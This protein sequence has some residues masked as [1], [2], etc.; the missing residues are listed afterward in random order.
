MAL[1]KIAIP[2]ILNRRATRVVTLITIGC[3]VFQVLFNGVG[4]FNIDSTLFLAILL[5]AFGV[6]LRWRIFYWLLI[7]ALGALV[8]RS[9]YAAYSLWNFYLTKEPPA[10]SERFFNLIPF[11]SVNVLLPCLLLSYYVFSYIVKNEE[12]EK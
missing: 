5:F 8:I 12:K 7:G 2:Q 10:F 9:C 6:L 11:L 3:A 1:N 4:W